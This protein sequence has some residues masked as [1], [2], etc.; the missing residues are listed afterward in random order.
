M[1]KDITKKRV[2]GDTIFTRSRNIEKLLDIRKIYLKFE[3]GNPTGT[4]KDRAS[5]A[6]LKLANRQG[7]DKAVIASCG[8]FGASFVD[9][10]KDFNIEVHVYI[11]EGYHTPRIQD[12]KRQGGIIHR[13]SGTYEDLV[14]LSGREAE[15]NGWF[16]ANPGAGENTTTSM[17]AYTAISKEIFEELGCAPDVVAVPVG[18]GTTLAGIY[19]GFKEI[20]EI[21][22]VNSVPV[23][24][25]ASTSGGNPVIKCFQ[26]GKRAIEDLDPGEIVETEHNEPLVSWRSFDGQEALDAI[27]DSNGWATYIKD[28]ELLDFSEILVREEGLLVLPASAASLAAL[29]S[30]AKI[31]GKSGTYV[32]VLTGRNHLLGRL[33]PFL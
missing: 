33:C 19:E 27:W 24:V 2:I 16:N 13:V 22:K 7:Y 23:M 8:N 3:G 32:A 15:E 31:V 12:M 6:C 29:A 17:E 30:Y 28:E 21:G 26:E 20:R 10:A 5:Y 9:L 1:M 18:N 25:A 11:P 14:D 4:M